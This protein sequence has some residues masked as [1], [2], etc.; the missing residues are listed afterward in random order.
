MPIINGK[1]TEDFHLASMLMVL[2]NAH[3]CKASTAIVLQDPIARGCQLQETGSRQSLLFEISDKH[4]L[5]QQQSEQ[6]YCM[7]WEA[8][9]TATSEN[10]AV[11]NRHAHMIM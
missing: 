7:H 1:G 10:R 8:M 3:N 9:Y 11:R 5:Q 6:C 2:L 4:L